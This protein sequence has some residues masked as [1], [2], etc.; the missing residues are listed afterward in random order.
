MA[1]ETETG[2]P[3]SEFLC[4]GSGSCYADPVMVVLEDGQ[5]TGMAACKAHVAEVRRDAT[6]GNQVWVGEAIEAI[7]LNGRVFRRHGEDR[8]RM[9]AEIPEWG[10]DVTFGRDSA[11]E[12][13]TLAAALDEIERLRV[14]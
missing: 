9:D 12:W 7:E 3:A 2:R 13:Q 1:T 14:T 11:W 6:R 8:W 4:S 10:V 5:F